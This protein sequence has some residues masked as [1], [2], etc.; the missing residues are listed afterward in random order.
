MTIDLRPDYL[1]LVKTILRKH[2]PETAKVYVFGSRSKGTAKLF[3]DLDLAIDVDGK[4]LPTKVLS[5]LLSDFEES[6]LPYKVDVIDF[7]DI[8]AEF[9]EIVGKDKV[10]LDHHL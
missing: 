6:N 2:L 7:N 5:S 10:L 4:K 3:S 8:S 9:Q 1:E